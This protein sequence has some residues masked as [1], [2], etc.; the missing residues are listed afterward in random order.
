MIILYASYS[1][2]QVYKGEQAYYFA[3]DAKISKWAW[4]Y[5]YMCQATG[6]VKGKNGNVFDPQGNA[7]RAE[8]ATI[9]L[10]LHQNYIL[11]K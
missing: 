5:V 10:N 6:L 1:A 9:L 2:T 3:D 11:L 8:V 4:S 7:T